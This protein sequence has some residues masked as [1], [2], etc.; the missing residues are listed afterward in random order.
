M[1]SY[2]D[3]DNNANIYSAVMIGRT[4]LEFTRF[5]RWIQTKHQATS[6]PQTKPTDLG[7]ESA[8]RL[9]SST[10]T[11]AIYYYSTRRLILAFLPSHG[12]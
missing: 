9:P 1:I 11:V 7:C 5:I 3:D 4:L 10:P 2:N 12:G 8:C 6:N